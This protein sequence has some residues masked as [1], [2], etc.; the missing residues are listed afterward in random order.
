M[1]LPTT[2]RPVPRP[3]Q[4][5]DNRNTRTRSTPV[6]TRLSASKCVDGGGRLRLLL[7]LQRDPSSSLCALSL[8]CRQAPWLLGCCTHSERQVRIWQA[9]NKVARCF[10]GSRHGGYWSRDVLMDCRRLHAGSGAGMQTLAVGSTAAAPAAAPF[11]Q[12]NVDRNSHTY[13][14]NQGTSSFDTWPASA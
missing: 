11:H 8:A 12:P 4:Q 2:A 5:R 10:L 14:R 13:P 9:R 3:P 6:L 1:P 7:L